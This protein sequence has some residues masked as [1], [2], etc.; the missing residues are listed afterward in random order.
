MTRQATST[1][2]SLFASRMELLELGAIDSEGKWEV[3]KS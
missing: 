2:S 3:H 1:V